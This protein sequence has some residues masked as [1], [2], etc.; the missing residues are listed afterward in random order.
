MSLGAQVDRPV[1]RRKGSEG[2]LIDGVLG[3]A[4]KRLAGLE[5]GCHAFFTG[6]VCS[7]LGIKRRGGKVAFESFLPVDLAGFGVEATGETEVG[8]DVQL[9][10][11]EQ[12]RRS[13]RRSFGRGPSDVRIGDVAGAV[14]AH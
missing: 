8:D 9:F 6:D 10:A 3:Q 5:Y 14:G 2:P 11:Y 1:C 4:F 12:R 7:P 13:V